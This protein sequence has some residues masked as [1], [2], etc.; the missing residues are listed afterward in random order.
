[1]L[2]I[3]R[4]QI[5][6]LAQIEHGEV[7]LDTKKNVLVKYVQKNNDITRPFMVIS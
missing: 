1:M 6:N 4:C 3:T 2:N 7:K 5:L